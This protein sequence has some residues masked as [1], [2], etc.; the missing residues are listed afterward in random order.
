MYNNS[1]KKLKNIICFLFSITTKS[2]CDVT[3]EGGD[4]TLTPHS[5]QPFIFKS[6][7]NTMVRIVLG[8]TLV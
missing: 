7:E 1:L 8:A 5:D 2:S 6:L 3:A 4:F